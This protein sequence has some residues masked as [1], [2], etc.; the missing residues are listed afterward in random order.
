MNRKI[1][2]LMAF[3]ASLPLLF[4]GCRDRSKDFGKFGKVDGYNAVAFVDGPSRRV[5][6][7]AGNDIEDGYITA[8]DRE[9]DGRF[10]EIQMYKIPKGH[11][12][13]KRASL[14]G[15]EQAYAEVAG[16]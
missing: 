12:L 10:D 1:S 14:E 4:G 15:M 2:G 9:N 11:P 5:T 8:L 7:Y 3:V 16:K 6:I 13:E